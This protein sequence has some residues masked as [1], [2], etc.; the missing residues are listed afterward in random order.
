MVFLNA[1]VSIA[2]FSKTVT[3]TA[4]GEDT[5]EELYE[6]YLRQFGKR[7]S[8][9]IITMLLQFMKENELDEKMFVRAE[10]CPYGLTKLS[11][12]ECTLNSVEDVCEKLAD[13]SLLVLITKE[14]HDLTTEEI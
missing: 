14:D 3:I 2:Q 8:R 7:C 10:L 1:T 5:K 13:L 9:E 11:Y 6:R 12:D 4:F